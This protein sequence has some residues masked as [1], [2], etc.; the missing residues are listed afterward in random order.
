MLLENGCLL[1]LNPTCVRPGCQRFSLIVLGNIGFSDYK[2]SKPSK[3]LAIQ[4]ESSQPV[5]G[6]C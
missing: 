6:K 3:I 5:P 1:F 4:L 2:A